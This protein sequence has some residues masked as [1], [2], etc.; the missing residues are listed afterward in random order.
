MKE[1]F[2]QIIWQMQCFSLPAHSTEGLPIQVIRPGIRNFSD[3]P[4][5]SNARIQMDGLE[6]NGS[7]EIHI[8]SSEWKRH[9]HASDPAYETVILHVVWEEDQPLFRKDGSRIPTLELRERVSLSGILRYR[10]L[11]N[12][13]E[14]LPCR[15]FLPEMKSLIPE[16]ML[17]LA[18]AGRLERRAS[19]I[20]FL[21][22][23]NGFSWK[24]ALALQ[25]ARCLGMKGNEDAM[26]AL[27]K[28]LPDAILQQRGAG[29]KKILAWLQ[30]QSGFGFSAEEASLQQEYEFLKEG[31][32]PE[33]RSILW[34]KS[35][36]RPASFP[37]K[38]I[39]LLAE[40]LPDLDHFMSDFPAGE[41]GENKAAFTWSSHAE[42]KPGTF[43]HR[44]LMVNFQAPA[45]VARALHLGRP[46]IS[47]L[48]LD[49]L[50]DLTAEENSNSR[51]LREL[52]F[53]MRTA[54]H[55]QGGKELHRDWCQKRRCTECRIGQEILK[56]ELTSAG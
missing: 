28:S 13:K 34:K 9:G 3:G 41:S 16:S 50:H 8:R 51:W 22:E 14:T 39:R 56:A 29:N 45:L 7:V 33:D 30:G 18:L 42:L 40:L 2:L 17:D 5:F 37:L 46:E 54:G 19:E 38:R 36:M 32:Q 35:G 12:A 27:V 10:E 6:W 49:A 26:E 21:F 44:H 52:G 47:Q 53:P 1:D 31:Y 15:K 24:R 55:S 43:L 4:D 11:V 25:L 48:A 23:E 20:L